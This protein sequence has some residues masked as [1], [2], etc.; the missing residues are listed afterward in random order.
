MAIRSNLPDIW[1]TSRWNPFREMNRLQRR[2]DY[3]FDDFFRPSRPLVDV[4]EEGEFT[5]VCD[6]D[7]TDSHFLVSFDLPGVKKDDVKIELRDNQLMVSGNRKR[8]QRIE[9]AN[10][11][12]EERLYGAFMQ[13][14]TLPSQVQ[15][16]Q[17]EANFDH[18]VLK[19]SIP[20]AKSAQTKQIPIK[21]GKF[22]ESK[23]A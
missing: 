15:P 10:R 19:I 20:K 5:P 1:R 18:G 8:E 12:S 3:L 6:V 13:S 23:A 7:E 16:E 22:I 14:F 11:L 9:R 21:E 2:M 4:E 17:V